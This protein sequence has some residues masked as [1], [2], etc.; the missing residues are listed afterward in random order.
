MSQQQNDGDSS[1][2]M[3]LVEIFRGIGAT[4]ELEAMSI[5]A[6][7]ESSGVDC[8]LVG[9]SELPNLPF[10]VQVPAKDFE[11]A[12]EVLLEAQAAGPAAAEE[13]ER[14]GEANG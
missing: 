8:I 11:R 9:T 1:H 7:L 10:R 3:D 5:R 6:V 4:A 14:M 12:K 13:A 2:E